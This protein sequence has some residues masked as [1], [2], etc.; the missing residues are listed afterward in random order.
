MQYLWLFVVINISC[1]FYRK[2]PRG[3]LI[4][5]GPGANFSRCYIHVIW[6][7]LILSII[8]LNSF[9]ELLR[10]LEYHYRQYWNL[11]RVYHYLACAWDCS[12]WGKLLEVI[13]YLSLTIF[14]LLLESCTRFPVELLFSFRFNLNKLTLIQLFPTVLGG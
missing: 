14:F 2:N 8:F 9:Q 7:Q 12:A 6:S 3:V 11:A 13:V 10:T 5:P 1:Y 4:S